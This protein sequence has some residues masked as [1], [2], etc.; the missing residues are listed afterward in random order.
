MT[1]PKEVDV[2]N[3]RRTKVTTYITLKY[4]YT[5]I[6]YEDNPVRM[7]FDGSLIRVHY[8]NNN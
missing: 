7:Y 8:E 5:D 3:H 2:N 6:T 1:I 4:Q